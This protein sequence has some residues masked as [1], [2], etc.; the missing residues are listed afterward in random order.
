MGLLKA[1]QSKNNRLQYR[2]GGNS[3]VASSAFVTPAQ[4]QRTRKSAPWQELVWGFYD[5]MPEVQVAVRY[6]ANS[7]SRL[8]LYV[9]ELEGDSTPKEIT[10]NEQLM[11]P[12]A[13]LAD[14]FVGQTQLM[15]TFGYLLD[16]PG[17]SYLVG[18]N[19]PG[20]KPLWTLVSGDEFEKRAGATFIKIDSDQYDDAL[21][22]ID[23][24]H[25]IQRIWRRHPRRAWEPDSP[26]RGAIRVLQQ[27]AG[28]DASIDASSESRLR[29][30][31]ILWM[32]SDGSFPTPSPDGMALFEDPDM[33]SLAEVM[34][35]A[36]QDRS[37]ASAK[38]PILL[39]SDG[40]KPEFITFDTPFD[41][42][43]EPLRLAAIKR[44][45]SGADV[46]ADVILGLSDLNHWNAYISSEAGI[47][48]S[49]EPTA[50]LICSALTFQ[51]YQPLLRSW[52]VR[53][54]EKYVIWYDPTD[55]VARPD[56]SDKALE[57][58]DRGEL[59]GAALRRETG[60]EE[61][62]AP[63]DEERERKQLER[64]VIANPALLA[65][66]EVVS[67]LLPS[68]A[69]KIANAAATIQIESTRQPVRQVEATPAPVQP[70]PVSQPDPS[71]AVPAESPVLMA[72]NIAAMRG[73]EAAGKRLL[74]SAGR[75]V[76]GE[77][78]RMLP[79]EL[80]TV[81]GGCA[82]EEYEKS[83]EAAFR[84]VRI[85]FISRPDLA[86]AVEDYVKSLIVSRRK[87]TPENLHQSLIQAGCL[88]CPG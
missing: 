58:Y 13:D 29:G 46:P 68:M 5:S 1:F 10:N 80:H 26:A 59:S 60:F 43:A 57:V 87:H 82:S 61:D 16:L 42:R 75:G 11:R 36:I 62:D 79:W 83:L 38:V 64:I 81:L 3:L 67:T 6:K 37:S 63:T 48:T 27:I 25:T 50:G 2:N 47:K 23:G 52:G 78:P 20:D 88:P 21:E 65:N 15:S 56:R 53:D 30:A 41:E 40:T 24:Q 76:R 17:E 66:T 18:L 72:A 54:P 49:I 74:S 84:M 7:L 28:I 70:A 39:K 19:R 9:G 8:R 14:G 31:G 86:A 73:L 55:L 4:I 45:A 85:A 34:L 12:L 32:G 77:I 51:Y 33:A 44:Y 35:K 22:L 69:N 71:N